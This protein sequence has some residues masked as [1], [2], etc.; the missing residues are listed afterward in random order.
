MSS[1]SKVPGPAFGVT[2][3]AQP[4]SRST[5]FPPL[6]PTDSNI[7]PRNSGFRSTVAFSLV[8]ILVVMS[9]LTFIIL[10][11]LTMFSQ[12]QRAFRDSMHQ[13]D[14]LESGRLVMDMVSR[15][16]EQMAAPNS[17]PIIYGASV[18]QCTNFFAER[19]SLPT[20]QELPGSAQPRA[21]ELQ[22]V[23]FL[24]YFNQD[25]TGIGYQ[26]I[27]D[28]PN[29]GVGTLYRFCATNSR[30]APVDLSRYF[31]TA[32]LTNLNRIADGVVHFRVRTFATNGFP[33]V[34][35][36]VAQPAF[37]YVEDLPGPPQTRY[38]PVRNTVVYDPDQRA[39]YFRSNALPAYV[40]LELGILEPQ[41]LQ[42]F[43]AIPVGVAR[44][45]YLSNH[46][47][48]V[49]LFRQRIPIRNVD[50]SAYQ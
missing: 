29:A 26:V 14:V 20:Y 12:T 15:E 38:A 48:N 10:G 13:V 40:E 41:I 46:V 6:L 43:R 39:V 1:P 27:S 50:F 44:A 25:W 24:N 34:S 16:L 37:F 5:T 21:N 2:A 32:P 28:A 17:P 45:Q 42:H 4:E 23:F 7:G 8:E 47:G 35:G 18:W 49:H 9:L 22:R 36:T 3:P 31:L 33:L 30:F 19:S 11:L